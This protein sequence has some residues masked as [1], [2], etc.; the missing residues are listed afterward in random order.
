MAK[1]RIIFTHASV[2]SENSNPGRKPRFTKKTAPQG[3]FFLPAICVV[4]VSIR[5]DFYHPT[6][7]DQS[8]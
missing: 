8:D 7:S 1:R 6:E 4:V 2:S 5:K 3:G